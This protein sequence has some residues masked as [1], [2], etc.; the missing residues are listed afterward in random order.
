MGLAKTLKKPPRQVAEAVVA[1][2][3]CGHLR[4]RRDRGAG[5]HQP[6]AERRHFS[7]TRVAAL[8]GDARLGVPLAGAARAHRD[9]LL[10]AERRQGD[11]RRPPALARSSATRSRGMLEFAGPRGHPPEPHRRLGHAVRHADRAPARRRRRR[12]R[13]ESSVG[14]L[15]EFYQAARAKFDAI[16]QFAERARQRVVLLQAGDAADARAVA[17][18][19]RGV[20]AALLEHLRPARRHAARRRRRAARASTTPTLPEVAAELEQT[21]ARD[22]STTARSA[23][24][25]RAS[26]TARASRCR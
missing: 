17:R 20:E 14:E 22:G 3:I 9:R 23:C 8:A 25:R 1:R 24:S 18:A 6:H 11:A 12:G 15:N 13:P 2:R 10:G 5:L 19:R 4:S 21:R 16:R 7:R 26:R